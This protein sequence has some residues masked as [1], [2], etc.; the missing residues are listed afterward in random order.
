MS[1]QPSKRQRIR[2]E[3]FEAWRG[4]SESQ[5]KVP[6]RSRRGRESSS[7]DSDVGRF[8]MSNTTY[9]VGIPPVRPLP[10]E[11]EPFSDLTNMPAVLRSLKDAV[12]GIMHRYG[13]PPPPDPP[14]VFMDWPAE[15]TYAS[16]VMVVSRMIPER[17]RTAR[18]TILI[19]AQWTNQSSSA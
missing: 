5:P 18:P 15:Y 14:A 16:H 9:R 4:Q 8:S 6:P 17:P 7:D 19:I 3:A 12:L 11:D 2:R 1:S 13:V 10:L